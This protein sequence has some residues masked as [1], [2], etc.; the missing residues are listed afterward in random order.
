LAKFVGR[1]EQLAALAAALLPPSGQAQA[2]VVCN[3]QGMAGV[4]KSFLIERFYAEHSDELPRRHLKI[5][6]GHD[7]APTADVL[8]SELAERLAC[9]RPGPVDDPRARVRRLCG[10]PPRCCTST[11]STP[12]R[13]PRPPPSSW[14]RLP[15]V[16]LIVLTGRYTFDAGP[17]WAGG[18]YPSRRLRCPR[19]AA[20]PPPSWARPAKAAKEADKRAL[21]TALGGLPLAIP[22][23]ARTCGGRS[24]PNFL[25]G[26]ASGSSR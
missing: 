22:S 6:L 16:P 12:P 17:R 11:T 7:A 19:P 4:G 13:R 14:T 9:S 24:I 5:T 20:A 2:A 10:H 18:W 8:L 21:V 3:L 26:T 23:R 15:G 25:S 1:A